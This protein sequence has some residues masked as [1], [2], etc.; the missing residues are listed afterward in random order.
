LHF[1]R[2]SEAGK[3]GPALSPDRLESAATLG[4]MRTFRVY[5]PVAEGAAFLELERPGTGFLSQIVPPSAP[6]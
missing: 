2:G 6:A 3:I 4:T 5:K 1:G